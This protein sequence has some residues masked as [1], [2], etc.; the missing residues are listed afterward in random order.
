[1][2]QWSGPKYRLFTHSV[3]VAWFFFCNSLFRCVSSV[4]QLFCRVLPFDSYI[5]LF[6]RSL[7]DSLPQPLFL[8]HNS[9]SLFHGCNSFP[10]LPKSMYCVLKVLIGLCPQL[11]FLTH[12]SLLTSLSL[13]SCC[14]PS[15]V[16]CFLL[17]CLLLK[18]E[19]LFGLFFA[20]VFW[21]VATSRISRFG[22]GDGKSRLCHHEGTSTADLVS[23]GFP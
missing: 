14:L 7:I 9:L 11:H 3:S 12:I 20:C 13:S 1:M 15:G 16:R 18:L 23:M 17:V 8:F 19:S 22:E 4:T 10:F 2:S 5:F 21:A 6:L